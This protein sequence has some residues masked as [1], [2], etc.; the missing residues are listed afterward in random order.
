MPCEAGQGQHH[1]YPIRS[2]QQTDNTPLKPECY[3]GIDA[4]SWSVNKQ[5]NWFS[6]KMASG[7]LDIS[8]ASEKYHV[9]LGVFALKGKAKIAPVFDEPVLPDRNYRGGPIGLTADLSG[10]KNDT[11]LAKVLK[12]AASSTLSVVAGMVQ[13]ATLAG[14][15]KILGAAGEDIIANVKDIM[16]D[17]KSQKE[18]F[19]DFS[20][21]Q[22]HL[23]PSDFEGPEMYILF[24]RGEDLPKPL[25]P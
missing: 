5:G 23:Q 18:P 4:L 14:P 7:A 21:I 22:F 12:S 10:V 1:V 16:S 6:S 13:T 17:K 11:V 9:A 15:S 3:L 20:G 25:F 19:F 8:F 2:T 24:H